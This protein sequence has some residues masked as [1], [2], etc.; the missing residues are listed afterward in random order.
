MGLHGKFNIRNLNGAG[1]GTGAGQ[2][3]AGTGS[4]SSSET[5]ESG[6]NAAD[7]GNATADAADTVI[8]GTIK[9]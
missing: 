4:E 1:T 6:T 9:K 8:E 2:N 5:Q 7:P 3:G